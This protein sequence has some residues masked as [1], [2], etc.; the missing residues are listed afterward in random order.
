MSCMSGGTYELLPPLIGGAMAAHAGYTSSESIAYIDIARPICF[1]LERQV[2]CFA[3]S[4]AAANTGNRIAARI[5]MMAITTSNSMSVKALFR[6]MN[7][8]PNDEPSGGLR[9]E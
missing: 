6:F 8:L 5:A 2:V 1:M 4:F 3:D 7:S 9:H